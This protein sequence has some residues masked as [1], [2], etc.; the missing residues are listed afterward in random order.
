VVDEGASAVDL[1]DRQEL[2]KTRLEVGVAGDV[3]D[4]ELERKLVAHGVDRRA[5]P[6]A[7]VATRGRVEGEPDDRA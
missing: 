7:E 6:L 4:L 1:D 2:T 3:D 5:R